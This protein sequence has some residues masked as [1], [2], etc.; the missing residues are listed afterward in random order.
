MSRDS[1]LYYSIPYVINVREDKRLFL[2]KATSYNIF[3]IFISQSVRLFTFQV[4]Q[5][6][7]FIICQLDNQRNIESILKISEK[8]RQSLLFKV[9]WLQQEPLL[10]QVPYL[11]ISASHSSLLNNAN[12]SQHFFTMFVVSS[13]PYYALMYGYSATNI[14]NHKHAKFCEKLPI[15]QRNTFQQIAEY[16]IN[17]KPRL[18]E[19][20]LNLKLWV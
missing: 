5:E 9:W 13:L 19:V 1:M 15:G 16:N 7:F 10:M 11:L 18:V 8:K 14:E 3:G 6:K 2:V 20:M 4:L 12:L 17:H